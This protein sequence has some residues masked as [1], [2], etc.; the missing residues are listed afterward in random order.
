M[1]RR[2]TLLFGGRAGSRVRFCGRNLV[3][4]GDL[5]AHSALTEELLRVPGLAA[6]A[7]Q[8]RA[9]IEDD[10]PPDTDPVPHPGD[11]GLETT[12]TMGVTN[13]LGLGDLLAVEQEIVKYEPNEISP[14]S[15][16]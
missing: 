6:L 16:T 7:R 14:T 1:R 13:V 8:P 2:A 5:R 9:M 4:T 11:G 15:R 10:N 12:P 3:P